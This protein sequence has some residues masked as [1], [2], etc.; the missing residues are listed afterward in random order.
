M[1]DNGRIETDIVASGSTPNSCFY[2]RWWVISQS[3]PANTTLLGWEA[4]W[5]GLTGTAPKYQSNAVKL[6]S[7]KIATTD[8]PNGTWSDQSGTGDHPLRAGQATVTHLNNGTATFSAEIT[9]WFFESTPAGNKK[10]TG[11][12]S[13]PTI[14][15][16]STITLEK[17]TV[18][19]GQAQTVT[20]TRADAAFTH[21]IV[22]TVNDE[23][24]QTHTNVTT[25]QTYTLPDTALP[26]SMTGVCTVTVTTKNGSTTVGTTTAT[27]TITTPDTT[28]YKPTFT[29]ANVS[30]GVDSN[31]KVPAG[32]GKI[33]V[34]H[35]SKATVTITGG[36]PGSG[37]SLTS[38]SISGDFTATGTFPLPTT[39]PTWTSP[40]PITVSGTLKLQ[41]SITDSRGCTTTQECTM[42]VQPW[43]PPTLKPGAVYRATNTGEQA[44]NGTY[45][46]VT[47]EWTLASV[48]ANTITQ[49]WEYKTTLA[50]T[51][52]TLTAT[53]TNKNPVT[54]GTGKTFDINTSYQIR[55]T[56]TDSLGATAQYQWSLGPAQVD[57]DF[58]A[59]G[60]GIGV[61]GVGE[62][63]GALD[64][65]W[66]LN[67]RRGFT[68]LVIPNT[69]DLNDLRGPDTPPFWNQPK[70]ADAQLI[71]NYPANIAGLLQTISPSDVFTYQFYWAY[72]TTNQAWTRTW[73]NNAGTATWYPWKPLWTDNMAMDTTKPTLADTPTGWTL[74]IDRC[75]RRAGMC[76]LTIT[77][78]PSANPGTGNITNIT[79]GTLPDGY[80]PLDGVT[81]TIEDVAGSITVNQDGTISLKSLTHDWGAGTA[82]VIR[83]A[84]PL[85]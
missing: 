14:P 59:D 73:Y 38:W 19:L 80:R 48:G 12:W 22:W 24:I 4:G 15:R 63:P 65:W 32:W 2:L 25:K 13:L 9:G 39:V 27:Y 30:L 57:I 21:D 50:T 84:Y 35:N 10:T 64:V 66:R 3:V 54:L 78:T 75:R 51:W 56:I 74:T 62:T 11:S 33:A 83:L 7:G 72:G 69:M 5:R 81:T 49:R 85:A 61:G 26:T 52:S 29:A 55:L 82:R 20:I 76:A 60:N 67:P 17:T 36:K 1:A 18:P 71:R 47:A 23:K 45:A 58:R 44:F 41:V 31:N 40:T 53:A 68:H 77:T 70:S 6:I 46:S 28:A 16:A 42:T 8:I 43:T 37:A 79:L 34:Q